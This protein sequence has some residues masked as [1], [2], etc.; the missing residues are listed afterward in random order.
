MLSCPECMGL[1][2]WGIWSW[3]APNPNYA[4]K[5]AA[6]SRLHENADPG[7]QNYEAQGYLHLCA[8]FYK[9]SSLDYFMNCLTAVGL[10]YLLS[11]QVFKS[12]ILHLVCSGSSMD[13]S[14]LPHTA[15]LRVKSADWDFLH[16]SI[17]CLVLCSLTGIFIW[18]SHNFLT[19]Y[20]L[21]LF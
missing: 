11:L 8:R 12:G 2:K 7:T 14:V 4:L 5:V 19:E 21:W 10:F 15:P 13:L 6:Y 9:R 16:G 18:F 1:T 20:S 17:H 3:V